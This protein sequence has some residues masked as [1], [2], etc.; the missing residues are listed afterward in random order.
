MR[1][2]ITCLLSVSC[3]TGYRSVSLKN[4]YS[5]NLD[6][7]SLLVFID[8]QPAGVRKAHKHTSVLI[9]LCR[10]D[11]LTW[12]V[13]CFFT[14][15]KQRRSCTRPPVSWRKS[16]QSLEV[17]CSCTTHTPTSS[18]PRCHGNTSA[19]SSA[20]VRD[21]GEPPLLTHT[22][23]QCE[24]NKAQTWWV[25]H[26]ACSALFR[27]RSKEKKLNNSKFY[28]WDSEEPHLSAAEKRQLQ[29][30][31]HISTIYSGLW[32]ALES[33]WL[34]ILI[35]F[36]LFLISNY[37]KLVSCSAL[38]HSAAVWPW[39]LKLHEW[40]KYASLKTQLSLFFQPSLNSVRSINTHLIKLLWP[41]VKLHKFTFCTFGSS[42]T[43]KITH[44]SD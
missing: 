16:R 7:A 22:H 1:A 26:S 39:H 24:E 38:F 40:C 32:S 44:L 35:L 11:S 17:N 42:L 18:K 2:D 13:S 25:F 23:R 14:S 20:P 28:S 4:G 9:S 29:I 41:V 15:S 10:M 3:S 12:V 30:Q 36:V 31:F 33:L 6:L 5:E 43:S 34:S 19:E 27:S 37:R 8:V 21:T